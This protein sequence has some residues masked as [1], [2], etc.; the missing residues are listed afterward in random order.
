M[1]TQF[2]RSGNTIPMNSKFGSSG[3]VALMATENVNQSGASAAADSA[4]EEPATPNQ[5][6]GPDAPVEQPA[7]ADSTQTAPSGDA[8]SNTSPE[9]APTTSTATATSPEQT[10]EAEPSGAQD[11]S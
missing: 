1:A 8:A 10:S 7:A 4:R 6:T 9:A 3:G 5:S 11:F 2:N